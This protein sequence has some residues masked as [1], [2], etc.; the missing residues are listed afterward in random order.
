V[1]VHLTATIASTDA[2]SNTQLAIFRDVNENF[3]LVQEHLE[4]ASVQHEQVL[5][6]YFLKRYPFK[7]N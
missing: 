6:K 7:K 3:Q 4:R 1:A 5:E 2:R